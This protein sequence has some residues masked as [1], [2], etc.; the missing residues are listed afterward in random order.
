MRTAIMAYGLACSLAVTLA[1]CDAF[2]SQP[3]VPGPPGPA[4]L[5][6]PTGPAGPKGDVGPA[7]PA[8]PPGP[9]G[10]AGPAGLK[11]EKGE[12]AGMALVKKASCVRKVFVL[13]RFLRAE[14]RLTWRMVPLKFRGSGQPS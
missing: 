8:G 1:G 7:G 9:K 11:G 6:G 3:P 10:E 4:G 13:R 14:C 5:G 12:G 2:S